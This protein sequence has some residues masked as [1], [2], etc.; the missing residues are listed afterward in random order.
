MPIRQIDI[1]W[2]IVVD[3]E[4]HGKAGY[5]RVDIDMCDRGAERIRRW[6]DAWSAQMFRFDV[7]MWCDPLGLIP[8]ITEEVRRQLPRPDMD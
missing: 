4:G 5:I 1:A 2:S 7:H 3:N 6:C 8:F